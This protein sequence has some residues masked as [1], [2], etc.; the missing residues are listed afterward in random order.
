MPNVIFPKFY[1][2]QMNIQAPNHAQL[3]NTALRAPDASQK[4]RNFLNLIEL[5]W[6]RSECSCVHESFENILTRS[7]VLSLISSPETSVYFPNILEVFGFEQQAKL[8]HPFFWY[9]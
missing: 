6:I 1:V 2:F 5:N 3:H 7:F 4:F 8:F 9:F